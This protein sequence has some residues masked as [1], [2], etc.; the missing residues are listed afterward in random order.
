MTKKQQTYLIGALALLL[1]LGIISAVQIATGYANAQTTFQYDEY[2]NLQGYSETYADDY[3]IQPGSETRW[4]GA[5]D[6]R[7][8]CPR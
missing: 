1:I 4:G 3:S 7:R 6:L 5:N 8:D 2:G